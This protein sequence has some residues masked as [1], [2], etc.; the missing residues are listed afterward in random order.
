MNNS[1][2]CDNTRTL[3]VDDEKS[4]VDL[5]SKIISREMPD[6]QLDTAFNGLEAVNKF[7]SEHHA[8]LV[9]DLHMPVMSGQA[10]FE[11]IQAICRDRKW[12]MPSF[13]FC[14][15]FRPSEEFQKIAIGD[16]GHNCLLLKPIGL[17]AIVDAVQTH[18][19]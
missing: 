6:L 4:I 16:N 10:A 18:L 14:T 9:M 1:I 11:Q 2:P 3:I 17:Q 12:D 15:G 7:R 13:V 19:H 8:V 5:F